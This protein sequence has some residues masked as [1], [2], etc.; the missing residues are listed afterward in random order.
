MFG[1]FL[2]LA[3]SVFK[4]MAAINKVAC[5]EELSGSAGKSQSVFASRVNYQTFSNWFG[6]GDDRFIYALDFYKA[7][8]T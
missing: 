1:N 7:E 5:Q 4:T 6:A 8:A 2:K 3:G